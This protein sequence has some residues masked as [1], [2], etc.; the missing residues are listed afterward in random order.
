MEE[1]RYIIQLYVE[2]KDE[3]VHEIADAIAGREKENV[4]INRVRVV[5]ETTGYFV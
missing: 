4:R 1:K 2:V 5:D 3:Q